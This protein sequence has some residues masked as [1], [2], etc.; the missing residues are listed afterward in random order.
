MITATALDGADE[1][2]YKWKERYCKEHGIFVI[3]GFV[4]I[5]RYITTANCFEV[6]YSLN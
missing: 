3:S 4:I 2:F 1:P 6:V 5:N